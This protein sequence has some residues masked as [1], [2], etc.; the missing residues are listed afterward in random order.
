[1]SDIL[2]GFFCLFLYS[3]NEM[4]PKTTESTPVTYTCTSFPYLKWLI[5]FPVQQ[6]FIELY[7]MLDILLETGDTTDEV[8]VLMK[9]TF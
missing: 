3:L 2:K 5:N 7:H 1:M 4:I 6:I 9:L 8:S